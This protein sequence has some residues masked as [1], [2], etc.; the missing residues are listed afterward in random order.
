[1]AEGSAVFPRRDGPPT[2]DLDSLKILSQKFIPVEI[3]AKFR[4]GKKPARGGSAGWCCLS[5]CDRV[6]HVVVAT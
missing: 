5:V 3:S 1:M 4:A 2:S 6:W